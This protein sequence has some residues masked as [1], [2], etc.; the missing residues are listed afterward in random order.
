MVY[1]KK[2]KKQGVGST[3]SWKPRLR[4]FKTHI[5]KNVRSGKIAKHFIDEI[6]DEEISFKY[7]AFVIIDVVNNTSGLTCNQIEDL[8]PIA[9]KKKFWIGTLVTQHQ[10]ISIYIYMCVCMCMMYA[11]IERDT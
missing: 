7:L 4:N 9:Q 2:C 3:I 1:C 5:K 8:R 6:C 11:Y 10:H